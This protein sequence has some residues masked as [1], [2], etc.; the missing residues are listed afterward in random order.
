MQNFDLGV[1]YPPP[2]LKETLIKIVKIGLYAYD[3][4][5]GRISPL[6]CWS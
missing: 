1:P 5:V 6:F 3:N 2:L 4:K